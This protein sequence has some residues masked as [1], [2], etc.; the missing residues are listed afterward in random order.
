MRA[1][2]LKRFGAPTSVLWTGTRSGQRPHFTVLFHHNP[3]RNPSGNPHLRIF[4]DTG[5]MGLGRLHVLVR[6]PDELPEET[7]RT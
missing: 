6:K 7:T 1:C 3:A 5:E 4:H 2:L